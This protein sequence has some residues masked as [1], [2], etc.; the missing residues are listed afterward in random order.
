MQVQLKEALAQEKP[1]QLVGVINA[2]AALLAEA[3][4]FKALYL[5]GAGVANCLG[6]ADLGITT[7]TEV[8]EEIR[9]IRDAVSL[10]LLVDGDTGWGTSLTLKR[11][12]R[13]FSRAGAS[14][15][16]I[17]DQIFPKRCGHRAGKKLIVT[18]EMVQ[19]IQSAVDERESDQFLIVARTDAL[20]PEGLESSIERAMAYQE[21]GAD[22]VFVEAAHSL[23]DYQAFVKK[24]KVPVLANMTEFGKTP[25]FSLQELRT[26]GV[27]AVLYPLT[28]FRAMNKA[29]ELVYKTIRSEGSQASLLES[30]RL[31][32]RDE[33]Y[34]L[35]NYH[36]QEQELS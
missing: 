10:P 2:C 27:L 33:L 8:A 21:A 7:Y 31:Q 12:I 36:Q 30:D 3:A 26:S 13:E 4:G 6:L 1:L 9:K 23:S 14:G 28:A 24:L 35:L 5:S 34:S 11:M 25:L 32:T 19:R 22:M 16:H 20:E 15:V 18:K 17:E 29:A